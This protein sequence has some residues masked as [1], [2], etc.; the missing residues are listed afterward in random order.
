MPPRD[1]GSSPVDHHDDGLFCLPGQGKAIVYLGKE[2]LLAWLTD[3]RSEEHQEVV[4]R[5]YYLSRSRAFYTTSVYV[6][7]EL[8]TTVRYSGSPAQAAEL[9]EKI[10]Q[11]EIRVNHG[12]NDWGSECQS[13]TPKDVFQAGAALFEERSSLE[14]NFPEA[15][16]ILSAARE[17]RNRDI[18]VY[19]FTFDG[20][21]ARL[22]Q[23]FDLGVLPHHTPLRG[24]R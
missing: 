22:A 2:A 11:S 9:H 4:D 8:Y 7:V 13:R 10:I 15:V 18:P 1:R 3:I 12:S 5:F 23:T 21:L 19:V 17:K 14:I 20:V 16:L 24:R 6:L